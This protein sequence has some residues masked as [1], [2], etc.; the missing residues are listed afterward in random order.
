MSETKSR[1]VG[2]SNPP[3]PLRYCNRMK[4][5]SSALNFVALSRPASL[6]VVPH[7]ALSPPMAGIVGNGGVRYSDCPQ[8]NHGGK[9]EVA[10]QNT[11]PDNGRITHDL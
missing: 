5:L 8:F 11:A 7:P 6:S 1:T 4:H 9:D 2:N 3:T 10:R